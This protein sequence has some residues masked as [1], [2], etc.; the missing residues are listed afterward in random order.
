MHY[1][2]AMGF[3]PKS[4]VSLSMGTRRRFRLMQIALHQM[5]HVLTSEANRNNDDV[6]GFGFRWDDATRYPDGLWRPLCC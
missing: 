2:G 3:L 1:N 6:E 5:F 4:Q